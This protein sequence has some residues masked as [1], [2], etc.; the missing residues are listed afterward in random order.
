MSLLTSHMSNEMSHISHVVTRMIHSI[1]SIKG[2]PFD[3]I[4]G[5]S[6]KINEKG[7]CISVLQAKNVL[8]QQYAS[9]THVFHEG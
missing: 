6:K 2:I 4:L 7:A 9:H 8:L 1:M 3:M 5:L